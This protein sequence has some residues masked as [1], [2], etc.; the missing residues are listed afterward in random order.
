MLDSTIGDIAR[1][2]HAANRE[3]QLIQGDPNPSPEWDRAPEDQ[4]RSALEGVRNALD[5]RSPAELHQNWCDEKTRN[6]WVF[7]T[8][9]DAEIKTHPCLVPYD[10]LPAGQRLKDK[11]FLRIVNAMADLS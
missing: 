7:G 10:Q 8:F 1:V 2:C 5:G 3:L 9:K 11:V 4:R 6:G